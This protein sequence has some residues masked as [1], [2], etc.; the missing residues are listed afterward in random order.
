MS[1]ESD[2][3][4]MT[5]TVASFL[6]YSSRVLPDDVF[7]KLKEMSLKEDAPAAKLVYE[8]MFRNLELAGELKRPSCQDTGV[9]QFWLK[10]G[11][12]FPLINELEDIL[13]E[14]VLQATEEAP[15]RC[16]AVATFDEQNTGNNIG[17]GVPTIWWD[18]VPDWDGCEIYTYLAGG[19]CSLPGHAMVLMPSQGYEGVAEFVLERMTT[20][21]LNACPPLLVGVGIGTSVETA[22]LNAKKALM[23]PVGS[24]NTN[25]RAALMETLLEEAINE[26]GFGPQGVGGKTSVMG[27]NV[28]N[29]ARHIASMGVCVSVSCW[30]HRRGHMVFDKDLRCTVTTHSGFGK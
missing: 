4:K 11:S 12:S 30:V 1:R 28:V 14:A 23:R 17:D 18:I 5:E 9:P 10:C 19:G 24:H 15:L 6:G 3:A 27:V 16:N 21:A 29:T 8:T 7:A 13:T 25:E 20:Y 26:I 22:A 2:I